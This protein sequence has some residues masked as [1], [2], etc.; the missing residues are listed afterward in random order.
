MDRSF[1]DAI[2][3][4]E[5]NEEM[6]SEMIRDCWQEWLDDQGLNESIIKWQDTFETH[7]RIKY[8]IKCR[9]N[10]ETSMWDHRVIDPVKY[11]I[12]QMKYAR[13]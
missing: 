7:A 6:W 8:G 2:G 4:V 5:R 3:Y 13:S 9:W 1:T 11:S 12:F 10:P